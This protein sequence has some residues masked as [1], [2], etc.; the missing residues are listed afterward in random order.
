MNGISYEM[1][2]FPNVIVVNQSEEKVKIGRQVN[3]VKQIMLSALPTTSFLF[4]GCGLL[5]T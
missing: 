2:Q 1:P 3:F 4:F 5:S